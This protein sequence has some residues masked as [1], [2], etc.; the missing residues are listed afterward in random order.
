M[1]SAHAPSTPPRDNI[2]R[3]SCTPVKR[4]IN[5]DTNVYKTPPR[6]LRLRLESNMDP[7]AYETPI[8]SLRIH[9]ESEICPLAPERGVKDYPNCQ[10]EDIRRML[11]DDDFEEFENDD[12]EIV[13]SS[14]GDEFDIEYLIDIFDFNSGINQAFL[15][16]LIKSFP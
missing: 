12:F 3:N 11:F 1:N 15:E 2:I 10:L 9:L 13:A 6:S 16:E 7:N 4:K 8:R 5:D 14:L